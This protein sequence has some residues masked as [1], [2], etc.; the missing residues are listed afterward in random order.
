ML[1]LTGLF[2]VTYKKMQLV[3][4]TLREYTEHTIHTAGWKLAG[5][6]G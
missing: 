3:S 6:F 5:L 4:K 2:P 1:A